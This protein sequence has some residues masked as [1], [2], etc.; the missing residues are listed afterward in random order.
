[1]HDLNPRQPQARPRRR[2]GP[3]LTLILLL[4]LPAACAKPPP[5]RVV[6]PPQMTQ[7]RP[8]EALPPEVYSDRITVQ[9]FRSVC[10][11]LARDM[12]IQPFVGRA[13]TPPVVTIRQLQNKTDLDVD[14]QIFQETIRAKLME[15]SRGAILFRDDVS[16][17]DIVEERLRSSGGDIQVTITDSSVKSRTNDRF[18]ESQYERGSLS[19]RGRGRQADVAQENERQVDMEQS[20]S[21]SSRVAQADYFL[22]GIIYQ[23]NEPNA[24]DTVEGMSYFQYQFRV[25]DA[26]SG[27]IV[28][29]KMLD[30]KRI[31]LYEPVQ[32]PPADPVYVPA[33]DAFG[34]PGASSSYVPYGSDG[35]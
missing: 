6:L 12:V 31:G 2:L 22:R 3:V 10:D 20:G 29:E 4:V 5:K 21:V 30:S 8:I 13:G 19:G 26:R 32:E 17:N 16:Y 9:D 7:R 18:R 34:G 14:E 1:M 24:L 35:S 27:I 15:H 28:W 11:A 25:V 33:P 23:L